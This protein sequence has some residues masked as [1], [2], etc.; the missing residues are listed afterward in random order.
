MTT[1]IMNTL[2]ED[3]MMLVRDTERERIADLD[4]DALLDLH[5]RIR[6]ARN[7]YVKL[8]RRHLTTHFPFGRKSSATLWASVRRPPPL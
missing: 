4:E 5:D 6:R 7:K 3:E 8:Y 1:A 2:T